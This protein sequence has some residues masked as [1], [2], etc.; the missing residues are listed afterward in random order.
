MQVRPL[1]YSL[2]F[3]YS[4]PTNH[5]PDIKLAG[6]ALRLG[7][8][9]RLPRPAFTSL[10]HLHTTTTTAA[11]AAAATLHFVVLYT[12]LF[13]YFPAGAL[14]FL[15]RLLASARPCLG[16]GD[17]GRPRSCSFCRVSSATSASRRAT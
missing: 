1:T 11:A 2:I 10:L 17:G 7:G 13:P 16:M 5:R 3:T 6:I 8:P 9:T 4:R 12:P 15:S 14:S